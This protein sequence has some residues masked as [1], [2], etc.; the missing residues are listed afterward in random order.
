MQL[1]ELAQEDVFDDVTNYNP[2]GGLTE[3]HLIGL[4]LAACIN[5]AIVNPIATTLRTCKYPSTRL[6]SLFPFFQARVANALLAGEYA[7][8]QPGNTLTVEEAAA[9]HLYSQES[10]FYRILNSHLRESDRTSLACFL[11]YLR[12]LL[13]GL[14]KLPLCTET[15]Y[16]GIPLGLT[17]EYNQ[18]GLKFT[19]WSVTSTSASLAVADKFTTDACATIFSIHARCIVDI[20]QYSAVK[21][22]HEYIL[23]PGIDLRTVPCVLFWTCNIS[24]CPLLFVKAQCWRW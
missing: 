15:V 4:S 8:K 14:Y 3:P 1:P 12:L 13:G 18:Q 11:P 22:E 10:P 20:A 7:Q 19:W 24:V 23:L 6:R 17:Q 9:V 5:Y 2:I 21:S 16:R